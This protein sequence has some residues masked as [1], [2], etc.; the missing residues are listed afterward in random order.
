MKLYKVT[1]LV[2]ALAISN[3]AFAQLEGFKTG[4]VFEDYGPTAA[5]Q[6][7]APLSKDMQF[8]IAFD[9]VKK[10]EAGKLNRTIESA[11]RFIN[12]HVTA[13]VPAEN[14]KIAIVVHG[15]AALDL[16]KQQLYGT[17]NDGATNGSADAIAQLQKHGVE[18]RLCGQSAA[19]H[20]IT[21]AD[22]LPGVKMDLSAMTAH[23][24]LQQQGYTLNPF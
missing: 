4:P 24:L 14:I 5:V 17:R 7:D 11:A 18:F 12:M 23:A 15:G 13:G 1:L 20:K 16:T 9:V 6:T 22:L 2:S 8:S 19:A 3:P 10:A 21:N